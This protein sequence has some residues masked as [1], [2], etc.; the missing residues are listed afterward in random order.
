MS[1]MNLFNKSEHQNPI[2]IVGSDLGYGQVKVTSG[3]VNI[4]FISAVGKPVS[5][6]SRATPISGTEELLKTLAVTVDGQKYYIGHNAIVNSR[7]GRLSLRQNKAESE[8]NRIKFIT[9]LGLLTSENQE[10]AEFD[11]VTGLPVLEFKNQKDKLYNMLYN[12]GRPFEFIM[13][14]GNHAVKKSIKVRNIKVV[15]QG[16]GAFYSYILNDNGQII[17]D[18]VSKVSGQ[19]MV[20]DPGYKTTDIVTMENGRYIEPLSDQLNKGVSQ[21][22]Q[23]ILRLIMERLNVKKE[24]KDI[25]DIVRTG[26]FFYNRKEYDMKTIIRDAV[27]PYA[28]DIVENLYTVSND[29]LGGMQMVLLTGGGAEL[30]YPYV[31]EMLNDTVE[32]IKIDDAEFSNAHGYYKYG[33]LLKSQDLL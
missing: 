18:K 22:H 29:D 11:V 13:H 33:L 21:V 19:V 31:R 7:N 28:E 3:N 27:K 9:S 26:K 30:I 8:D 32:V 20:V 1:F 15:S 6:F 16:E 5:D 14:Y 17:N 12:Y 4:K 24:L 2:E 25:D 10:T 23:E